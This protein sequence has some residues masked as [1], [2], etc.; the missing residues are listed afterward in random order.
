[1]VK[2]VQKPRT[3]TQNGVWGEKLHGSS[4]ARRE[5][6]YVNRRFRSILSTFSD[7]GALFARLALLESFKQNV[8]LHGAVCKNSGETIVVERFS[9]SF[10]EQSGQIQRKGCQ[11]LRVLEH[12][13]GSQRQP[14]AASGSQPQPAAASGSDVRPRSSN[15]PIHTRRGSG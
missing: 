3:V 2:N 15:P 8:I 5:N 7:H 11:K 10:A 13:S 12:A 9:F 14:A 6:F 4:P 1:M